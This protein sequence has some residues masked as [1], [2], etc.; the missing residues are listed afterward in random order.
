MVAMLF[1]S[2]G[3]EGTMRTVEV[4]VTLNP[5][6]PMERTILVELFER[7][8]GGDGSDVV[9][10]A[11]HQVLGVTTRGEI[12]FK[13]RLDDGM[14]YYFTAR[15]DP[16]LR[17]GIDYEMK[18]ELSTFRGANAPS[19]IALQLDGEGVAERCQ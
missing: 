2:C 12:T 15:P 13:E 18:E 19:T 1:M 17:C 8:P 10:V 4:T 6:S 7:E 14:E 3:E 9:K 11:G 16:V 5:T